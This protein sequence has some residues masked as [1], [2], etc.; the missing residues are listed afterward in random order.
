MSFGKV[1]AAVLVANLIAAAV[2]AGV[3]FALSRT[4]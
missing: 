2:T 1:V 3:A 4:E